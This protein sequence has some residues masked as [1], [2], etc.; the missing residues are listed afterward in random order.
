[1]FQDTCGTPGD[2][3]ASFTLDEM[4]DDIMLYWLTNS[5]ASSARLYWELIQHKWS[6]AARIDQPVRVP[7]GFS[8]FAGEAVRKSRRWVERRYSNVRVFVEHSKGGHFLV[9]ARAGLAE[10]DDAGDGPVEHRLE[11][12]EGDE[13]V[14]EIHDGVDFVGDG[15]NFGRD[16]GV[17]EGA[18]DDAEAELHHGVG[19]V[20]GLAGVPTIARGCGAGDDLRGVACDALAVECRGGDAALAHV[21]GIVGGDEAFAEEDLHALGGCAP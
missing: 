19:D 18:R 4:L 6:S 5:G 16:F 3:E 20:D 10:L 9:E 14:V 21:D 15:E 7:S 8:M 1:M 11:L 12:R 2:A 17:E 13:E